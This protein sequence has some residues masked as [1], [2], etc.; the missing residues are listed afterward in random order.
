MSCMCHN[1]CSTHRYKNYCASWQSA[2]SLIQKNARAAYIL[3]GKPKLCA[4]CNYA[5]HYEVA[6]IRDVADF[7]GTALIQEINAVINLIALCPNH[8]WEFD[9]NKLVLPQLPFPLLPT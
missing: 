2:R 3:S 9:N 8:H 1:Y 4:I 5:Q 6:H 7:P